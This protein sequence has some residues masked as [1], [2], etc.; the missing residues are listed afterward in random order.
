MPRNA[1]EQVKPDHIV[2]AADIPDLL[3]RLTE[4]DIDGEAQPE[5]PELMTVETAMARLETDVIADLNPPGRA[6]GLTCPYCAGALYQLEEG[7]LVRFRC[8]VGHA[9]SAQS[10]VSQQGNILE[11]ALWMALRSL[12]ERA[13]L[14]RRM[15][16]SA[17]ENGRVLTARRLA[18]ASAHRHECV[19]DLLHA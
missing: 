1:I 4:E 12:E 5:V 14:S 7:G 9:W 19:V 6:S 3:A 13:S 18:R 15:A 11:S 10:L 2:A 16:M 8:R 17:A